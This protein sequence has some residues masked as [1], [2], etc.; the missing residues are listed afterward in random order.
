MPHWKMQRLKNWPPNWAKWMLLSF[1]YI[2]VIKSS[3]SK[4]KKKSGEP[5]SWR[6]QRGQGITGEELRAI[7]TSGRKIESGFWRVGCLKWT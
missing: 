6:P 7:K 5:I 2:K 1:L 4:K 3:L